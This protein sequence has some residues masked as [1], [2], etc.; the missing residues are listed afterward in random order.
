MI[1]F[2]GY[3]LPHFIPPPHLFQCHENFF[4]SGCVILEVHDFRRLPP[5]VGAGDDLPFT[6][7]FVLLRPNTLN[8]VCGINAYIAASGKGDRRLLRYYYL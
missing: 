1:S 2:A 5:D 6:L 4:Y 8:L 7:D 3:N